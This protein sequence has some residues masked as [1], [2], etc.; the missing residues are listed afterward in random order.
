LRRNEDGRPK[1]TGGSSSGWSELDLAAL[2]AQVFLSGRWKNFEELEENLSM[3][4]LV[5]LLKSIS[6]E[7]EDDRRF[8]A[9]LQGIN[10]G[11]D[12][13]VEDEDNEHPTF[14]EI[15]MRA[16]GINGLQNDII[17]LRG[18]AAAAKG[19]GINQGLGYTEE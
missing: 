18:Q 10:L 1:S 8:F 5:Q 15:Q 2:E 11:E 7:K 4:E 17:G 14:E 3:P 16:Q 12:A 9:S 6:K 19:F 13:T